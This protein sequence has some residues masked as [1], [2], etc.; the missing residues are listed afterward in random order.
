MVVAIA[1]FGDVLMQMAKG[2]FVVLANNAAL[3]QSPESF[4]SIGV[5]FTVRIANLVIDYLMGHEVLDVEISAVFIGDQNGIIY[6]NVIPNHL[7]KTLSLQVVF[8]CDLRNDAAAPRKHSNH[9]RFIG[10][11]SARVLSTCG[12][13][14]FPWFAADVALVHLNHAAQQLALFKHGVADSHSHVPR[15]VLVDF[16]IA[17]Q[18][19]SREPFFGIQDQRD[20][21]EPFLQGQMGVMENRIYRDAKTSI[22]IVAMMPMFISRNAVSSAVWADRFAMPADVFNVGDAIFFGWKLTVDLND[23]H[24]YPLL[25]HLKYRAKGKSCQEKSSTV[26]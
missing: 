19:A 10:P 26:N 3:Q 12:L 8:V 2:N 9:R 16:Q 20:C 24:D 23:V 7:G 5:N 11:T 17:C 1:E 25:V 14:P 22:A 21:Q 13:V 15:G 18:L 6:S 4:D